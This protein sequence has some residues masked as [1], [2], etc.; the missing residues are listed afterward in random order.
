MRQKLLN[1][2]TNDSQSQSLVNQK[3]TTTQLEIEK[4]PKK[5]KNFENTLFIH[6]THENRL[7][8][9]KR[10]LHQIHKTIF[11]QSQTKNVKMIVGNSNRRNTA[12]ELIRKRSKKWLL[13]NQTPKSELPVKKIEL[14]SYSTISISFSY[15]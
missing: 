5:N 13:K 10:G 9:M 3:I 14:L 8:S 7:R 11:D 12:H 6:H 2:S 15:F 1:Q 4:N